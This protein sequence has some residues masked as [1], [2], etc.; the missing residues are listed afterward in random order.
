MSRGF[1]PAFSPNCVHWWPFPSRPADGWHPCGTKRRPDWGRQPAD[2]PTL[3]NCILCRA[4][5]AQAFDALAAECETASEAEVR[6]T[7]AD[8]RTQA[9]AFRA[10]PAE[11]TA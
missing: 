11:A 10:D 2:S 9:A 7:A 6:A 5:A 3:V 4:L 8:L 1:E